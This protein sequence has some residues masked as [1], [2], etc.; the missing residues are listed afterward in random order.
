MKFSIPSLAV[1]LVGLLSSSSSRDG[2]GGVHAVCDGQNILPDLIS[3][4]SEPTLGGNEGPDGFSDLCKLLKR[5]IL[6]FILDDSERDFTVFAPT[7]QA[8]DELAQIL[9]GEEDADAGIFCIASNNGITRSQITNILLYHVILDSI[10]EVDDALCTSS[11]EVA[12]GGKNQEGKFPKIRCAG[13]ILGG[14]SSFIVG[15]GNKSNRGNLPLLSSDSKVT[16]LDYCNAVVYGIDN[17]ILPKFVAQFIKSKES[18]DLKCGTIVKDD[19]SVFGSYDK[20]ENVAVSAGGVYALLDDVPKQEL[21]VGNQE[22][23]TTDGNDAACINDAQYFCVE[24]CRNEIEDCTAVTVSFGEGGGNKFSCFWYNGQ[25]ND[26]PLR[27]QSLVELSQD[28]AFEIASFFQKDLPQPLPF[29]P[30]DI[31]NNSFLEYVLPA[32]NCVGNAKQNSQTGAKCQECLV[33]ITGGNVG[34]CNGLAKFACQE[35]GFV[36]DTIE[37]GRVDCN[38]LCAGEECREKLSTALLATIGKPFSCADGDGCLFENGCVT[39]GV[40]D[41]RINGKID[42]Y[43]CPI[44]D[45]V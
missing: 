38:E 2:G 33:K 25:V 28:K 37:F 20:F 19:D 8:F 36:A 43:T 17:V 24:K 23:F 44:K 35:E 34:R 40:F 14:Q 5:T 39:R 29:Q 30:S 10:L 41:P 12:F 3:I 4:C 6:G 27:Q 1:V 15:P 31:N 13:D 9:C 32:F 18:V 22:L 11:P 21:E 26:A 7:N 16:Q 42:P 45:V